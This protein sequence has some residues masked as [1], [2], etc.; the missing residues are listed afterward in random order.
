MSA[1]VTTRSGE[2]VAETRMSAAASASRRCVPG[3]DASV[4]FARQHLAAI[5]P[6]RGDGRA[7]HV[8][9]EV[10]RAEPRHLAGAED[11]E[12]LLAQVAE[13][14]AGERDRRVAERDRALGEPGIG[15][16]TL[17]DGEG[18][19]EQAVD[20]AAGAA[21]L[22]G[23]LVGVLDLPEDLRFADDERIESGRDPE[24]VAG[25]VGVGCARTG[26]RRCRRGSRPR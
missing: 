1:S 10:H 4:H 25:G 16:D 6:S 21:R 26:C 15:A 2:P 20:H 11:H 18:A 17:A 13:D 3:D 19:M 22:A 8:L 9:V 7:R 24:Q 14:L 5:L 23:G 12:V